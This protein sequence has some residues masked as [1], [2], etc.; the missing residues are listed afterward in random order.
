MQEKLPQVKIEN[1]L[2]KAVVGL[3]FIIVVGAFFL[4]SYTRIKELEREKKKLAENLR[5]MQ[6]RIKELS[7]SNKSV[8]ED[9]FYIEKIG[10]ENL[11][12]AKDKEVIVHI[13]RG[14][15]AR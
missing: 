10:R 7:L 3:L 5:R 2:P 15:A 6:K 12:L 1:L 14:G 13:S 11:G 4:P 9:S 8:K